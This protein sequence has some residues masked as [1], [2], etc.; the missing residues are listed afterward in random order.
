MDWSDC[1]NDKEQ[2]KSSFVS[3][4]VLQIHPLELH[5][6][7][8]CCIWWGFHFPFNRTF[9]SLKYF[10]LEYDLIFESSSCHY[11]VTDTAP[12][13]VRN[14]RHAVNDFLPNFAAA[15]LFMRVPSCGHS[16]EVGQHNMTINVINNCSMI[17][18]T[19]FYYQDDKESLG[20][21]FPQY[22][23]FSAEIMS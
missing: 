21:T 19:V 12:V 5:T 10:G 13:A 22:C 23:F 20:K 7:T 3:S 11:L 1:G 17:V 18:H 9:N 15:L 16:N 14:F 2:S 8:S 6:S 4:M